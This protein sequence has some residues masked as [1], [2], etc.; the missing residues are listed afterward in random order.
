M[1]SPLDYP[2][3]EGLKGPDCNPHC[4]YD[5]INDPTEKKDLSKE[6]PEIVKSFLIRTMHFQ[7]SQERC[8]IKDIMD[9]NACKFMTANGG[10][11][12]PWDKMIHA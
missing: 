7:R 11:W 10:Y 6:N 2:C 1:W 9:S 4:L 8:K 3:T 5:I 12:R